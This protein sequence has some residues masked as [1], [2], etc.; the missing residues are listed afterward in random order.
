MNLLSAAER[1]AA[2]DR[3]RAAFEQGRC[4]RAISPRSTCTACSTL[5]PEG[6]IELREQ[7]AFT[8]EKCT[9]CLACLAACPAGAFS[10]D[11]AVPG[12]LTCAARIESGSIELVCKQ[13]PGCLKGSS[14][15]QVAVQ[16]RGCLAGLGAGAYLSLAAL[17]MSRIIVRIDN[18]PDCPWG[19][20]QAQIE[21]QIKLACQILA[22]CRKEVL[23]QTVDASTGEVERPVWDADNPP[24]SRRD[25]FRFAT[26]QGQIALARTMSIEQ[27]LHGSAPS[28]SRQRLHAAIGRLTAENPIKGSSVLEADFA[29]LTVTDE[30][31]ACGVCGRA[32]P[33]G[34]LELEKNENQYRLK[35]SAWKCTGCDLCLRVCAQNA[36]QINHQ[37][38]MDQVFGLEE[39][40]LRSG[41][42][43]QCMRCNA[44][45]AAK[46]GAA[47]CPA[48]EF[49]R[50]NPFGRKLPPGM[51]A[52]RMVSL[53]KNL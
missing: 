26:R 47:Y 44:W 28:R 52:S 39:V 4:L 10:A 7:V 6:A 27:V 19:A 29:F 20:L 51:D 11:D 24:L 21:T 17:G 3:S 15:D 25:L 38:S 9:A 46:P 5:C 45:F 50:N 37:P 34:A 31:T 48:C 1:L 41:E 16:L 18:C 49:R 8:P 2:L 42:L 40:V 36:I 13:H 14:E 53:R 35:F 30:C 32:C 22:A 12:L 33:A 23:L 43:A